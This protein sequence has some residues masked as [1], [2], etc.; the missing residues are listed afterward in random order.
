LEAERPATVR[1]WPSLFEIAYRRL[2][3][4][5][6]LTDDE[7]KEAEAIA[8]PRLVEAIYAVLIPFEPQDCR[9]QAENHKRITELTTKLWREFVASA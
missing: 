8:V 1:S 4:L 5:K 9:I 6:M 7:I 2:T 3:E